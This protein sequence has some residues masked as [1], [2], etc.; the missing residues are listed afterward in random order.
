MQL[1]ISDD[2]TYKALYFASYLK[3]DLLF[4][5][6]EN[7][8]SGDCLL[9]AGGISCLGVESCACASAGAVYITD[10]ASSVFRGVTI[11]GSVGQ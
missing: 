11:D 4:A 7:S 2:K 10:R 9:A 3:M 5:Q 6:V 1:S 8:S